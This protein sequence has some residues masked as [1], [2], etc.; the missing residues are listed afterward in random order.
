MDFFA[1]FLA[2]KRFIAI[3]GDWIENAIVGKTSKVFYSPNLDA[4]ADFRSDPKFYLNSS[5]AACYEGFI[6]KKFGKQI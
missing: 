3:K 2:S 6:Y 5:V 4:T 1:V